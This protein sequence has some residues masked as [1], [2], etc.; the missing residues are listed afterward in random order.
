MHGLMMDYPLTIGA[1]LRRAETVFPHK[2]I[3]TRRPDRSLHRSTYA[4]LGRRAR[5]LAAALAGLGVAPGDRVAT[6]AWNHRQHL[7]AYFGVPILGAVLHTLNLRL[8]PD[9]LSFIV[10]HAEDKVLL[11]DATLLPVFEKIRNRVKTK[12]VVVIGANGAP[13]DGM[14]DYESLV[15]AE[16]ARGFALPDL[17]ERTAAAMCYTTG[18]TGRPKGVLYSH[19]ALVLHSLVSLA[20]DTIGI[21]ETDVVLPVVPMFHANA[22]GAPYTGALAGATQVLP[23]PHLDPASLLDLF[24]GERITIALG[25]PTV[26]L[27][28]LQAL[29]KNP[30]AYDLSNLR[31]LL[32]G[33]SAAPAAM[34]QAFQERHNLRILHAWGMTETTPLGTVSQVP[35]E[36]VNAPRAEQYAVRAKQG[37][38]APFVE[39][40]A[41]G[42]EGLVSWTGKSMGELEVRG[43]WIAASYF[44]NEEA[45]Q[46]FTDDG[47]FRT[48]DIVTIDPH[49]YIEIQDRAK[50]LIK[51]GGEWISSVALENAL[52]GHPAV[53][54]AAVIAVPHPKWVERP[55]AAV[56]VK[57]GAKVTANELREYLAE[58]FARWCVPDAIEFVTEIPRTA[59]G[60]FLKSALRAR[61]KDYQFPDSTA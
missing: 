47:W 46:A 52:M 21:S 17:D 19:R 5:Q 56:V 22:W 13:P 10:N 58:R 41:R 18:T 43:P 61:F 59:A 16:D 27:A 9:E 37:R 15:G 34:I 48:G 38:P 60:K 25:V 2:T 36:L 45:R 50:D 6:L 20:V 26:W 8:H 4:D 32:V 11:V 30:G 53:A 7:E 35:S 54:E 28:V 51:S 55:L 49:G 44:N 12:H 42:A 31:A 1:I 3:V 24:Q 33:G 39:I 14:L 29:D 23:G 40:R 57:E